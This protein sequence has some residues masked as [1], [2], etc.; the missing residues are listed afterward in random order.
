MY[1]I[2]KVAR[3]IIIHDRAPS[4]CYMDNVQRKLPLTSAGHIKNANLADF[5][6]WLAANACSESHSFESRKGDL[7]TGALKFFFILLSTSRK[8]LRYYFKIR[9]YLLTYRYSQFI[10]HIHSKIGRHMI[11]AVEIFSL[12]K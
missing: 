3:N 1:G 12:I 8:T 7:P 11:H 5:L 4:R 2:R 10:I 9:H 6:Q